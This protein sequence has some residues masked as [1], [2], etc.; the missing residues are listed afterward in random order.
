MSLT[1]EQIENW[2]DVGATQDYIRIGILPGEWREL[3]ALALTALTSPAA[4]VEFPYHRTFNAIADAV[5]IEGAGISISVAKFQESYN[6]G[7]E[8]PSAPGEMKG[9][10]TFPD[11]KIEPPKTLLR[12]PMKA[13]CLDDTHDWIT[14]LG[15]QYG[16]RQM[17]ALLGDEEGVR[18]A[19]FWLLQI[20]GEHWHEIL[21]ALRPAAP[22]SQAQGDAESIPGLDAAVD[23]LVDHCHRSGLSAAPLASAVKGMPERVKTFLDVARET[24]GFAWADVA[25]HIIALQSTNER[26]ASDLEIA[27]ADMVKSRRAQQRAEQENARLAGEVARLQAERR[28]DA[29]DGQA[30]LDEAN[31][32]ILRLR[33]EPESAWIERAISKIEARRDDRWHEAGG[34]HDPETNEP[35]GGASE[36]DWIE[37]MDDAIEVLRALQP[38]SGDDKGAR[39]E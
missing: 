8:S 22:V 24:A 27:T 13:P 23:A 25:A 26:L 2:R 35:V 16:V 5:K 6:T 34:S 20:A 14:R 10:L 9:G 12:A 4:S 28:R 38:A 29:L 19:D 31:N 39:D 18:Q 33:R 3:C 17:C 1:R 37:G 21:A 15:S 7:R 11:R 32:E 36:D 30:A